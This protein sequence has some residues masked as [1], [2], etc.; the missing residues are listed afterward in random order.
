VYPV[1]IRVQ[2]FIECGLQA[3]EISTRT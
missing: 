1:G 2:G 3:V